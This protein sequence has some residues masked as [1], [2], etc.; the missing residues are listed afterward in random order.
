[1]QADVSLSFLLIAAN[2]TADFRVVR[3]RQ[4]IQIC[5]EKYSLFFNILEAA[6]ERYTALRHLAQSTVT[7]PL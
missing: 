6:E 2:E 5:R 1:M 4:D 7:S 3:Q